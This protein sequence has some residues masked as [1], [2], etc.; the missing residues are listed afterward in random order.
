MTLKGIGYRVKPGSCWK[1]SGLS[2]KQ[3]PDMR[4]RNSVKKR[5]RL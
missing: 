4:T 5:I 3:D 2:E 1:L